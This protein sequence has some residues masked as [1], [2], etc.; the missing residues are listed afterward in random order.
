MTGG[1]SE[2]GR[3]SGRGSNGHTMYARTYI[4]SVYM[5]FAAIFVLLAAEKFLPAAIIE[6]AAAVGMAIVHLFK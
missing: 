5:I 2:N 1:V 3:A 6:R 4:S